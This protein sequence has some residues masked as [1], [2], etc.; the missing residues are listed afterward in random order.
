M[1]KPEFCGPIMLQK[2]NLKFL[3][4]DK[5]FWALIVKDIYW[6]LGTNDE[7][8]NYYSSGIKRQQIG[9]VDQKWYEGNEGFLV[10]V[11]VPCFLYRK[12]LW[13][14]PLTWITW[15]IILDAKILT[16]TVIL[17]NLIS[18]ESPGTFWTHSIHCKDHTGQFCKFLRLLNI[19]WGCC[20]SPSFQESLENSENHEKPGYLLLTEG[21]VPAQRTDVPRW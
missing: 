4:K 17:P 13:W 9:D 5:N 12:K 15:H 1:P 20:V 6:I 21:C 18:Q 3:C 2:H 16:W 14:L 8:P 19:D 7:S 11:Q 10:G